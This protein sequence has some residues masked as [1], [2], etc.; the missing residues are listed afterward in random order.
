MFRELFQLFAYVSVLSSTYSLHITRDSYLK[1]SLDD[2]DDVELDIKHSNNNNNNHN[3]NNNNLNSN[4]LPEMN[5]HHIIG[6][7]MGQ[8]K[9]LEE[10]FGVQNNYEIRAQIKPPT[11]NDDDDN[12]DNTNN[13][14]NNNNNNVD[15]EIQIQQ[16]SEEAQHQNKRASSINGGTGGN[17]GNGGVSSSNSGRSSSN[18]P[19]I[20]HEMASQLMLRSARGQRQYDVPQIGELLFNRQYY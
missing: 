15:N 13:N 20:P 8:P 10:L 4:E 7:L 17:V 19:V 18:M 6:P 16:P 5:H 12:N 1:P 9:A 14:N 2:L 11:T 3:N